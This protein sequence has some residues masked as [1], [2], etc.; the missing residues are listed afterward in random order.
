[1]ACIRIGSYH[2]IS[3]LVLLEYFRGTD[4]EGL[5]KPFAAVHLQMLGKGAALLDRA[6]RRWCGRVDGPAGL[7]GSGRVKQTFHAN[8][9]LV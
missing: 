2:T 1:M 8:N 4:K 3:L 7:E 6:K 5:G 9:R